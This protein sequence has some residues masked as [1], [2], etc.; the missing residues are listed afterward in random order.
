MSYRGG[1][2]T[3]G[4]LHLNA[5]A[6][7]GLSVASEGRIYFDSGTNKFLVSENGGAYVDL[8]G[9]SGWTDDGTVVRLTTANDQV[10][11][12]TTTPAATAKLEVDSSSGG[13]AESIRLSGGGTIRFTADATPTAA[14]ELGA[15]VATGRITAFIDSAARDLAYLGEAPF[16]ED[17]EIILIPE[18]Q[19]TGNATRVAQPVYDGASFLVTRRTTF[20]RLLLR[21]TAVTGAPTVSILVY[22]AAQGGSGAGS[23]SLVA[24]CSVSPG[25]PG[26]FTATPTEG[27]VTLLPGICFILIG[28]SSAGGSATFRTYTSTTNDLL[29]ANMNVNTHP[30]T[31]TTAIA[32]NTTPGTFDPRQNPTGEATASTL[33]V[34]LTVRLRNV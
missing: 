15:T 24:T 30:V 22:Q 26:N 12:G 2:T 32:A 27:T 7:P 28:R 10:G 4:P 29:N 16:T 11:V 34:G 18:G 8:V 5:T 33:N 17:D 3:R 14:G 21:I 9:T 20:N 1:G 31:F 13:F 6:S 25:A 19:V 23:T